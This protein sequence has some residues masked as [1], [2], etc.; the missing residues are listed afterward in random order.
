MDM[1]WYVPEGVI[2]AA[3]KFFLSLP[4]V[5]ILLLSDSGKKIGSGNVEL[6]DSLVHLVNC[7]LVFVYLNIIFLRINILNLVYRFFIMILLIIAQIS[8]L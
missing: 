4:M 3:I 7:I 2:P 5:P 1:V 6:L 8:I